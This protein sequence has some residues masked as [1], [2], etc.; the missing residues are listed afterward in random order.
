MK[1]LNL[2]RKVATLLAL[3]MAF[4]M[5]TA[6]PAFAAVPVFANNGN[7]NYVFDLSDWL[8]GR[9][10]GELAGDLP[11]PFQRA[12]G[13]TVAVV[14]EGLQV[15][16]DV[17]TED[18]AGIDFIVAGGVQEGDIIAVVVQ[19]LAAGE[20]LML[21][22]N[23]GG[24]W[25]DQFLGELTATGTTVTL[26]DAQAE[27]INSSTGIEV[28]TIRIRLN[29]PS[30]GVFVITSLTLYRPDDGGDTTQPTTEEPTTDEYTTDEYTTDEYTTD[31]YTTDEYTTDEYTTDEYTTDNGGDPTDVYVFDLI[32]WLEGRD[33]ELA[34]DLP[35]PFQR[36]GGPVV[37]VVPEGLQVAIDVAGQAWA[38]IDF[39]VAGGVQEGDIIAVVVQGL[40]AGEEFM[41][42]VNT[43]GA[44]ADQF[45]GALT[46]T[47]TT[48]TLTAAQAELINSPDGIAANT[49]RLRLNNPSEGVFIIT[50][51][52]LYRPAA[53]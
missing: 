14:P 27:L 23:T 34:G 47:G 25:A 13:P 44:W 18:W 41:L 22:V 40:A 24:A 17:A 15:A 5:F 8:E 53:A 30:E 4:S 16:I 7:A 10:E 48:V 49:I 37:T 52:T 42:Q 3:V 45:L 9:P 20:Q 1:K 36:A 31:E 11:A 32:S 6:V 28:N 12:G 2:R 46:A 19:G 33:G 38:G 50:S 21:Q 43:G 29:N 26:T 51:L 35:S 39:I